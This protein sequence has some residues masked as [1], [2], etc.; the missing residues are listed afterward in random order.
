MK[1]LARGYFWW[2]GLDAAIVERVQLCHVCAALGKYP[3]GHHY[4]YYYLPFEMAFQAMGV[5]AL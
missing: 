5:Y 4:Y 3:Q 2:P 1:S